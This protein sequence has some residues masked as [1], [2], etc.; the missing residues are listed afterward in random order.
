MGDILDSLTGNFNGISTF[1]AHV[2][3]GVM[4]VVIVMVVVMAG[5]VCTMKIKTTVV[6]TDFLK[7]HNTTAKY[8]YMYSSV[9]CS[10]YIEYMYMSA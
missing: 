5:N 6:H 8:M 10:M 4:V 1:T 9:H 2:G 7:L 3:D